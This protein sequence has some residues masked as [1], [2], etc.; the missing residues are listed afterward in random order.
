MGKAALMLRN[1]AGGSGDVLDQMTDLSAG[2]M[3]GDTLDDD[4]FEGR[5]FNYQLTN[6]PYGKE[7]KK[8]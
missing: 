2:I 6:P 1:I 5:T 8:E 7:W 3:L 4:R